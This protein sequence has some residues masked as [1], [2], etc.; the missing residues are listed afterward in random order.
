MSR[1]LTCASH[2]LWQQHCPEQPYEIEDEEKPLRRF[3]GSQV[4]VSPERR[5]WP[6]YDP[7]VYDP[8]AGDY[9]AY[10]NHEHYLDPDSTVEETRESLLDLSR[11]EAWALAPIR[12]FMDLKQEQACI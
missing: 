12:I 1:G 11:E 7:A 8:A 5:H 6:V 9:G 10:V 4:Y 2:A 3:K